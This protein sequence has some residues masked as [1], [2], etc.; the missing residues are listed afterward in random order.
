MSVSLSALVAQTI[1][2]KDK[3]RA[4]I[5]ILTRLFFPTDNVA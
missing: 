4:S 5:L 1:L 2:H 3:S